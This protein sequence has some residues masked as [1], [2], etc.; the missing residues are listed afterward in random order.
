MAN[1]RASGQ[2]KTGRTFT[3]K[4]TLKQKRLVEL[5]AEHSGDDVSM[6]KLMRKAGYKEHTA[7]HPAKITETKSFQQALMDAGATP[8]KIAN[9]FNSGLE[10][11]RVD[12]V[13]GV[14]QPSTVP[15]IDLRV[16][17]AEKLAKLYGMGRDNRDKSGNT[18]NTVI[19]QNNTDPN[20]TNAQ[21]IVQNTLDMLMQ[22][23]N[24][25][26]ADIDQD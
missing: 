7:T 4:P 11:N 8:Q 12:T 6:Y 23:T 19:Q 9:V 25:K 18:Y 16:R 24:R 2:K 21:D 3:K 15:D 5:I 17:T 10:A 20:Q 13:K 1:K 14:S 22:Q 26:Q